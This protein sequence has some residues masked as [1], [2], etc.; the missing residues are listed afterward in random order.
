MLSEDGRNNDS[1]VEGMFVPLRE[2]S[3]LCVI[4]YADIVCYL[5]R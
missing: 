3:I 2:S 4:Q 5:V 1:F